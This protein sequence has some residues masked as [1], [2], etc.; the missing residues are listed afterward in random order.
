MAGILLMKKVVIE[1]PKD[2]S[3]EV[4][5]KFKDTLFSAD[6]RDLSTRFTL[7]IPDE[8]LDELIHQTSSSIGQP[9]VSRPVWNGIIPDYKSL[10]KSDDRI[11]LIEVSTP[12]FVISPFVDELKEHSGYGEKKEDKT[13]IEKIIATTESSTTFDQKK[14]ILAAIAG[15]V[16]LIG[17]FLNNIG[18][19]I[20]AMLISPLLGPIYALA[21]YASIGDVKTTLRCIEILGLMVLML[22]GIA[23]AASFALSFVIDLTLTQEILSRTSPNAVFIL[24]AVLLGFATM[25]ALSKGIPEGIAGVAIAAALLP[26]AVV[27]G[28]SLV[29]FPSGAVKALVLTLQNVVGLIAGS[30]IGVSFLHIGP[31]NLF[32]QAQ[33]RQVIIRVAWFL[34]IIIVFLVIISFIL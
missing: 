34:L 15:I 10:V 33:S 16:A 11:T 26:P 12:D 22:V 24:M 5:A 27:T 30:I 7:Y 14:F 6:E 13:P 19:I 28:I 8:M 25:I 17:L 18:I 31:R 1:V 29:L 32:A 23:A 3:E 20:G 21:V 9:Q 4:R 2:K